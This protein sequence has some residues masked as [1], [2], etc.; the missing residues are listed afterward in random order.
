MRF[1]FDGRLIQVGWIIE[2]IILSRKYDYKAACWNTTEEGTHYYLV[3]NV[4]QTNKKWAQMSLYDLQDN[5]IKTLTFSPS[6]KA[7][8]YMKAPEDS[9]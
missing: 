3:L 6:R 4:L 2:K 8:L 1:R 7:I 5:Q 9:T